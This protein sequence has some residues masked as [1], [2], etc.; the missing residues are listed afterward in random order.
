MKAFDGAQGR[1]FGGFPSRTDFTS[2]PNIVFSRLLAEIDD[3]AELKTLLSVIRAIYGKRGYPRFTTFCELAD[4]PALLTSLGG[5][6]A[7]HHGLELGEKRGTLLHVAMEQ[8]GKAE[9]VYFLNAEKEREVVEKIKSG[10]LSLPG[11][12]LNPHPCHEIPPEVPNV[13]G[14]YEENIG[15]LTPMIADELREAEKVYPEAWL[16]DAIK[17]AVDENKRKWSYI[18]GILERWAREGKDDGTY[19]GNSKT[20]SDK[21]SKQRYNDMVQH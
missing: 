18:Q 10:E 2:V 6:E 4:N 11:L 12:S 21:Y 3:I 14:L 17:I 19:K 7:L 20:G 9:D 5:S 15:L 1:P 13:F 8:N 16:K